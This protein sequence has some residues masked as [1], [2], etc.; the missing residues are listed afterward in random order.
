[1]SGCPVIIIVKHN[2][3]DKVIVE[4]H[5][6]LIAVF[7]M[8][9]FS[10]TRSR[11]VSKQENVLTHAFIFICS[12]G[13]PERS[14]TLLS[15]MHSAVYYILYIIYLSVRPLTKCACVKCFM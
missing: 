11:G 13:K 12:W 8:K 4:P 15:S 1:M 10:S 2:C 6:S 5:N 9:V 14:P 3:F 7:I